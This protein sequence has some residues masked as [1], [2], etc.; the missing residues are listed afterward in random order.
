MPWILQNE[1]TVDLQPR[2]VWFYRPLPTSPNV[3]PYALTVRPITNLSSGWNTAG[4]FATARSFEGQFAMGRSRLIHFQSPRNLGFFQL[5]NHEP[6]V[7]LP[8]HVS[9]WF[10]AVSLRRWFPACDVGVWLWTE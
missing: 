4:F 2:D 1:V 8:G 6:A 3:D 9:A 10:V 5:I 7:N